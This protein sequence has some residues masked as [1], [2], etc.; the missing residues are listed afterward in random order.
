MLNRGDGRMFPAGFIQTILLYPENQLDGVM[1]FRYYST[2]LVALLLQNC[3]KLAP[4]AAFA[5]YET[6]FRQGLDNY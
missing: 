2:K 6:R 4:R 5:K 3:L 1:V